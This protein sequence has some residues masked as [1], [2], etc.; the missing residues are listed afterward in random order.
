[1]HL[2]LIL[3]EVHR[4]IIPPGALHLGMH[5]N[6]NIMEEVPI[7]HK[8]RSAMHLFLILHEVHRTIIPPSALHLGMHQ[9]TNILE[10]VPI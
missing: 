9:N 7:H 4:T 10:E 1:M 5:Q 3:H 2:F 6:T 8:T